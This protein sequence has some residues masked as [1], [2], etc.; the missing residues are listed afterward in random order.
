MNEILYLINRRK[1]LIVCKRK[2]LRDE[3]AGR[4][5]VGNGKGLEESEE[6]DRLGWFTGDPEA[7][8]RVLGV[9]VKALPSLDEKKV[10]E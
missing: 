5:S 7:A 1:Q 2:K 4:A 6:A 3:F 10:L 9:L 8:G